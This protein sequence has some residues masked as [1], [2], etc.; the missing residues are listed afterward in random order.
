MDV[1]A[2]ASAVRGVG[3][4]LLFEDDDH[5]SVGAFFATKG[6]PPLAPPPPPLGGPTG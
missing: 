3:R 5:M 6:R 2:L 4:D 1:R